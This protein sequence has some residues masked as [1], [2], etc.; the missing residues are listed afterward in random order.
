MDWHLNL[1][2]SF[3]GPQIAISEKSSNK[4]LGDLTVSACELERMKFIWDFS[5]FVVLFFFL[6]FH[7]SV[8]N[9]M[10]DRTNQTFTLQGKTS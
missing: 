5:V 7:I 1:H 10:I 9:L 6:S 3:C 4:R 2:P 8:T